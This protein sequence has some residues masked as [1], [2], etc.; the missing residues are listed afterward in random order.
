MAAP[1]APRKRATLSAST[2]SAASTAASAATAAGVSARRTINTTRTR[3]T[4]ANTA[5]T[6][7][8]ATDDLAKKLDGLA[9]TAEPRLSVPKASTSAR[10]RDVDTSKS[11]E[12]DGHAIQSLMKEITASLSVLSTAKKLGKQK[13]DPKACYKQVAS[14]LDKLRAYKGTILDVSKR[15][16]IEKAALILVG[17]LNDAAEVRSDRPGKPRTKPTPLLCSFHYL[18]NNYKRPSRPSSVC[19]PS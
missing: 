3:Q 1:A 16:E 5:A 10:K 19:S 6:A 8:N 12:M 2:P 15:L 14:A 18:C 9:L 13:P 17:H 7:P 11:P 4:P